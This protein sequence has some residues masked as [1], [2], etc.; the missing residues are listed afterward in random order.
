M[1]L[2]SGVQ[3]QRESVIQISNFF[4][5][6]SHIAGF[7]ILYILVHLSVQFSRSVMSDSL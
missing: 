5:F 6:F 2:V 3:P 1:L 4:G 7:L